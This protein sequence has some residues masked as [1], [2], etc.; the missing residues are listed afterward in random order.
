MKNMIIAFILNLCFS[1][2]EFVGGYFTNSVAIMS[3]AIH[4]LGDAISIGLSC[5]CEQRSKK[6]AN[7]RYTYGY[8]RY[9]VLGAAITSGILLVGSLWIIAR[10]AHRIFNPEPI[11]Y[12]GMLIFAIVGVIVNL[13]AAFL[14][15]DGSNLNQKAVNL[16]ML[17]DVLGWIVV[18]IG[19]IVIKFTDLTIIDPLMSMGVSLFI[20]L[21]SIS[22][23]KEAKDIFLET[24]PRA[25]DINKIKKHIEKIPNVQEII[26]LHV[27]SLDEANICCTAHIRI[28]KY[29]EVTKQ[30]IKEELKNHQ[31]THSTVEFITQDEEVTPITIIKK[32]TG[33]HHHHHHHRNGKCCSNQTQNQDFVF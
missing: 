2:F 4:D 10:S 14:T 25:I 13:L 11:N 24:A 5:F 1:I 15:K 6:P 28:K 17:E 27:W 30:C 7:K 32:K 23:I 29:D 16:H 22:T 12:D 26:D 31:I 18:L 19:A 3:D 20:L 21:G 8:L 33:H 9:S